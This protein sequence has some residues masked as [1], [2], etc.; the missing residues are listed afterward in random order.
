MGK[1]GKMN[2][3]LPTPMG[4]GRVAWDGITDRVWRWGKILERGS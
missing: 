1:K 2:M 4:G 3:A